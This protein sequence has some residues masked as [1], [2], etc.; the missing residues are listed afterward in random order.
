MTQDELNL[1]HELEQPFRVRFLLSGE[2]FTGVDM[3]KAA[4]DTMAFAR[5]R[6]LWAK[7]RAWLKS[8][9]A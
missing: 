9:A 2:F 6:S 1:M 5:L 8:H 7:H 3:V 4:K